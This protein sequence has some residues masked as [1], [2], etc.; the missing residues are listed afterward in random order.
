MDSHELTEEMKEE[1]K[2]KLVEFIENIKT[3]EPENLMEHDK[4]HYADFLRQLSKIKRWHD[5][6]T[7]VELA[8]EIQVLKKYWFLRGVLEKFSE[9]N[10]WEQNLSIWELVTII[11]KNEE[12]TL[13]KSGCGHWEEMKFGNYVS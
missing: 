1:I 3:N 8:E 13:Y 7:V 10:I 12:Y 6:W 5:K 11:F 9:E 4:N 2:G